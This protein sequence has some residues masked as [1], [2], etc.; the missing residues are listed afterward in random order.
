MKSSFL[1]SHRQQ[2]PNG[3]GPG[4]CSTS[5]VGQTNLQWRPPQVRLDG[6]DSILFDPHLVDLRT[7]LRM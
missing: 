2:R 7:V 3:G 1:M 4:V 5:V 6:V